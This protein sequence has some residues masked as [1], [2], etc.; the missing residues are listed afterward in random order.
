M[1]IVM[2]I[3]MV[4][5]LINQLVGLV[6]NVGGPQ[7]PNL[8]AVFGAL[9]I[10]ILIG[11]AASIPVL[12]VTLEISAGRAA[13]VWLIEV[14]LA[15]AIGIVLGLVCLGIFIALGLS[16]GSLF[17]TQPGQPQMMPDP[18]QQFPGNP[19]GPG[20]QFPGGPQGPG[21]QVPGMPSGPGQGYPGMPQGPGQPLPG[22]PPA[23]GQ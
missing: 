22:A 12:I 3:G 4:N 10:S 14:L 1:G 13:L 9:A 17:P 2:L 20:Q 8:G 15:T 19:F 11:A 6:L 5:G 16:S 21:Q 18:G 23:P 7:V